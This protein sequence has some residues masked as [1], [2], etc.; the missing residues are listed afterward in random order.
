MIRFLAAQASGSTSSSSDPF[1]SVSNFFDSGA[2][3]VTRFLLQVFVFLLWL[4]LIYWTYRDAQRRIAAHASKA[5][6]DHNRSLRQALRDCVF[7]VDIDPL[8][9]DLC[10]AV[11]RIE[12]ANAGGGP[13]RFDANIRCADSLTARWRTLFPGPGFD[14]GK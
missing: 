11:L 2:W 3:T 8:A 4:A 14:A 13:L 10:R 5:G 7:G 1:E 12:A 6:S 9:V